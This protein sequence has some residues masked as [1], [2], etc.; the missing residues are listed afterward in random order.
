ME[1][2]IPY[3]KGNIRALFFIFLLLKSELTSKYVNGIENSV[4]KV[5]PS[6]PI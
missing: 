4:N 2:A 3:T 1:R 5:N 6:P